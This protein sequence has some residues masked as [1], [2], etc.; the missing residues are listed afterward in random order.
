L[1]TVLLKIKGDKFIDN[2]MQ[3][4]AGLKHAA[5]DHCIDMSSND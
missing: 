5:D 4:L 2:F 1:Q 3:L